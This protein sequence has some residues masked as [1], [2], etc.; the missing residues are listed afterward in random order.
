MLS[1]IFLF[2]IGYAIGFLIGWKLSN[3]IYKKVMEWMEKRKKN[4]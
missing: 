1:P 3:L 4:D 2:L